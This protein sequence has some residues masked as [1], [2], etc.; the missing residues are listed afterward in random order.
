MDL[1]TCVSRFHHFGSSSSLAVSRL[2]ASSEKA[3]ANFAPSRGAY[4]LRISTSQ[5]RTLLSLQPAAINL[6]SGEKVKF[7]HSVEYRSALTV[8]ISFAFKFQNFGE[9]SRLPLANRCPSGEKD[10]DQTA[11]ACPRNVLCFSVCVST[12]Q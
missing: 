3:T 5:T 9:V 12:S 11:P 8:A 4:I 6:L 2:F 10:S 1:A 7:P